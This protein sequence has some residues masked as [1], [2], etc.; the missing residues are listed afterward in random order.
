MSINFNAE[1]YYDDFI[2]DKKFLKILFRPGY[3]VQAR[4]LNQLQ[5]ILQN[6]I[7]RVGDHLFKDGTMVIP[8]EVGF[9]NYLSYVKLTDS[10]GQSS[11]D[12]FLPGLV[13]D[14]IIGGTSGVRAKVLTYTSKTSSDP[15]MIYV[16]YLNSGT[17]GSTKV[18]LPNEI[19]TSEDSG[20]TVVV[21][22]SPATGIGSGATIQQGVFY[23][24]KNFVLV[25]TQTIVLSKFT[26]TPTTK[27][28]LQVV[29][30]IVTPEEDESLLDNAAGSYNYSAPGAHRY[31]IAL[32][33][34][35]KSY[36]FTIG[37]DTDFIEI[38]RLNT[39]NIEYLVNKTQYNVIEDTLARRTYEESG[40]YVINNFPILVKEFRDNN[41][42]T[43][44]INTPYLANDIVSY[45]TSNGLKTYYRALNNGLSDGNSIPQTT[46]T[47]FA[48]VTIW[49]KVTKPE[50]NNGVYTA[51]STYTNI[52][53]HA[54]DEAKLAVGL[55]AGKAYIFGY[56]V[57]QNS[58]KYTPVAKARATEMRQDILLPLDLG[59]FTIVK[60]LNYFPDVSTYPVV[61]LYENITSVAGVSS[62]KLV[63]TARIRAI[64]YQEGTI[65]TASATYKVFLFNVVM[66]DIP[67][68]NGRKY[69]F[70]NRVKQLVIPGPTAAST[71]TADI[72]L[73]AYE[74]AGTVI[75]NGKTI[76]GTG[77]KFLSEYE[78]GEYVYINGIYSKVDSINGDTTMVLAT[79][80]SGTT[81]ISIDGTSASV[82]S[83]STDAITYTSHGFS[84]GTEVSYNSGNIVTSSSNAI[85]TDSTTGIITVPST[86]GMVA[87]NSISFGNS[88]AGIEPGKQY[89]IKDVLTPTVSTTGTVGSITGTGPWTATITGMSSTTGLVVGS[90]ISATAGT[91]T[92]H[93]GTPTSVVVASIV[94][95]TSITYTVTGGTIPTAGTIT[96]ITANSFTIS[97]TISSGVA[98][99][100]IFTTPTT[101]I[102]KKLTPASNI[103]NLDSVANLS[104]NTKIRFTGNVYSS[105]VAGTVYFV[106]TI[107]SV[108][109]QITISATNDGLTVFDITAVT[110]T[111]TAVTVTGNLVTLD[112]TTG[113]AINDKLSF[114]GTTIGSLAAG[115]YYIKTLDPATNKVTLSTTAGGNVITITTS[116]TGSMTVSLFVINTSMTATIPISTGTSS[117]AFTAP[118]IGG[119][120]SGTTYYVNAGTTL[121][122]TPNS[123]LL[124][125]TKSGA[126]T[127]G[128][129]GKIDITAVAT[130]G[131]SHTFVKNTS[132]GVKTQKAYKPL[133]N[134]G[135]TSLL[136]NLP[137][138]FVKSV[139]DVRYTAVRTFNG[140]VSAGS[141]AA[142]LPSGSIYQFANPVVTA[143]YTI[144]DATTGAIITP[145]G[146]TRS[147]NNLTIEFT[148][149]SSYNTHNVII[150]ATLE[151][152]APIPKIKTLKSLSRVV[153]IKT[154]GDSVAIYLGK[155]DVF[156]ISSVMMDTGSWVSPTGLYST[157]I[158]SRYNLKN[159]QTDSY[160]G[161]SYIELKS[162][163]NKPSA[164]ITINFEYL[165][166][167]GNSDFFD[168][169]SYTGI[170]YSSIPD[171]NGQSLRD[172]IDFRPKV[173]DNFTGAVVFAD[174]QNLMPRYGT[175]MVLDFDY[176][177]GKKCQ[178][179]MDRVGKV[180]ISEGTSALTN[181]PEA[182]NVSDT[183]S[184]YK[185]EL[186]P[187]TLKTDITGV[188]IQP[189]DNKRYTMSD[190]GRLEKRISNLEYYTSLSLLESETKNLTIRDADGLEKFKSGFIVDNFSG[191]SVGDTSNP[192]YLNAIDFEGRILRPF[193]TQDQ[194]PF[195]EVCSS[196]KERLARNYTLGDKT[197]LGNGKYI[198][199][200]YSETKYIEQLR[201]STTEKVNPFAFFTFLGN[202]NIVPASDTW[203]EVLRKPDL[204]VST[205]ESSYNAVK[206][207]AEMQGVLGTKWNAWVQN[208][209]GAKPAGDAVLYNFAAGT[210]YQQL[211][212]LG[213]QPP[214][215]AGNISSNSFSVTTATVSVPRSRTGIETY[216]KDSF[217]DRILDD[218]ILSSSILPIMRSRRL[219]VQTKGLKADTNFYAYFAGKDVSAYCTPA[220]KI[221]F[222]KITG[223]GYEFDSAAR[224]GSSYSEDARLY[225]GDSVELSV[226]CGDVLTAYDST[227]TTPT[228][229]TAVVVGWEEYKAGPDAGTFAVWVV[230][231]KAPV[232]ATITEFLAGNVIKG[233]L[234]EAQGTVVSSTAY[235]K[236]DIPKTSRNGS[237]FLT[238]EVPKTDSVKFS[239]GANDLTLLDS[240]TFDKNLSTSSAVKTFTASGIFQERQNQI[241]RIRTGVLAT[242]N[243]PPETDSDLISAGAP[244][245]SNDP[246][247]YD[248]LAQTFLITETNGVFVTSI[249]LFFARKDESLPVIVEIREVVNGYPGKNVLITSKVSIPASKILTST[250]SSVATNVRFTSPTYLN[251][252][253]EYAIILLSD[254]DLPE[255][256]VAR[257]GDLDKE[258]GAQIG[259]QPYMGSFFKSQN[260]STWTADQSIDLKFKLYKAKFDIN[261]V[262]NVAFENTRLVDIDLEA[263]PIYMTANSRKI[264]VS[265][266]NHGMNSDSVV[267]LKIVESNGFGKIY[268]LIS[269]PIV[270]GVGTK[271]IDTNAIQAGA[272][273]Y[274]DDGKILGEVLSIQSNTQLTLKSNSVSTYGTSTSSQ[275]FGF[276]NPMNGVSPSEI[277]KVN[278]LGASIPHNI[279][280]VELDSYV[281][282]LGTDNISATLSTSSPTVSNIDTR[283]MFVG[284]P[285]IK[286]SG[287]GVFATGTTIASITVGSS[288]SIVL[289]ALPTTAGA[290]VFSVG[291]IPTVTGN[292]GGLGIRASRDVSYDLINPSINIENY[293]GTSSIIT[294]QGLTGK[295]IN[296]AQT[297][298]QTFSQAGLP[299]TN[300]FAITPGDNNYMP[301]PMTIA[302]N[303]NAVNLGLNLSNL[304]VLRNSAVINAELFTTNPDLSPIIN[305][306]NVS[307][308]AVSNKV[309]NPSAS[310]NI[311]PI[312]HITVVT[313]DQGIV[314]DG[315]ATATISDVSLYDNIKNISS[316]QY[317]KISINGGS[318]YT[319][320]LVTDVDPN[321]TYFTVNTTLAV[322]AAT[323]STIIKVLDRYF[324]ELTPVGGSTINKYV[325][326]KMKF[327][328]PCTS[329]KVLYDA[330]IPLECDVKVYYKLNPAGTDTDFNFTEYQVAQAA[331]PSALKSNTGM[332]AENNIDI[333]DLPEFDALTVKITM[334]STDSTKV[335]RLKDL[336]IIAL[337]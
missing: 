57:E 258:N 135:S 333:S 141:V 16:K 171:F 299:Y 70:T 160:Y 4:E 201:S 66:G 249:D 143:S 6:Q 86:T 103:I 174:D 259:A 265:H 226:S 1:P 144:I 127:G 233:N 115:E 149:L 148:G 60:N 236:G 9:D 15:S 327:A 26:R 114:S 140:Q 54:A 203:F 123:F 206:A 241:Q 125:S 75:V 154:I 119:L 189:V 290:V 116:G 311:D 224:A 296:G 200:P 52:S 44:V 48:G 67:N 211:A 257:M 337:A 36:D 25:E 150:Q 185:F 53:Q 298:Y 237:V 270:T 208:W 213:M 102:A 165:E 187:Y 87:N 202:M 273:L 289:S 162:G 310:M 222:N 178:L 68:T 58:V 247:W 297:P 329:F 223:K 29:E 252:N 190:I 276:I 168:V 101:T 13:G 22:V 176:Y 218:K 304:S 248:P 205:D 34:V 146:Y 35:T 166:H 184:L 275:E 220:Q 156:K 63:G 302:S 181:L 197:G 159:N 268:T 126:E 282:T 261:T 95:S 279:D 91:G 316:G 207:L 147:N 193:Y 219:I 186:A 12:G 98:G 198:T 56:E 62:G 209:V 243:A 33:L 264:R 59:Q 177:L 214:S 325:T 321:G 305:V 145:A 167:S 244:R 172:Y 38:L 65:G 18:F 11:T 312:D 92:L 295:S 195:T 293:S 31:S 130:G 173:T 7:S 49:Q 336:R 117:L 314:F 245:F 111:A 194:I 138:P 330:D 129:T 170:P 118:N 23:V 204:I 90:A 113:M 284:Q 278:T 94:S 45:T 81:S 128:S 158:T 99:V 230:N 20:I 331:T 72:A 303:E 104:I 107:D 179:S 234:S 17:N 93:G 105:I 47:T 286:T 263:D 335:P 288:G 301:V 225:P 281:I 192:D 212:A 151:V 8:G 109:K 120:S 317:I 326:R 246:G 313:G 315:T 73:D 37:E 287:D 274:R 134:Q 308:I 24:K 183:V 291:D 137:Y 108:N 32:N 318:T 238:F 232:T 239:T 5:S 61:N 182:P 139:S 121:S 242:R 280:S 51:P 227:G 319:E 112:S 69:P 277:F 122:P 28:C 323:V 89:Y 228:G 40:N 96:T 21:A 71:F 334:T 46:S 19:L 210:T 10:V 300:T 266:N 231:K 309:N 84:T 253:T 251:G 322:K 255:V 292:V 199:L 136:F 83:T 133:Y 88:I 152:S 161:I 169:D 3:G 164:P 50:Y 100:G 42:G 191:Q 260:G 269:S 271:F 64:E 2:E 324:N 216:I 27:V 306:E 124:Y 142:S 254:S 188:K 110:T 262:A 250:D 85:S 97:D 240:A 43:Y 106:R 55:G 272:I 39:G 267:A 155:P 153:S 229:V 80:V 307:I 332:F 294:Y 221:I 131:L 163:Q 320:Y 175:D 157:D 76:F 328:N 215:W 78:V 41:R 132:S 235:N 74:T 30:D 196:Q 180:I 14:T 77:T 82:V 283:Y 79:N 285:V 256:Y 217:T